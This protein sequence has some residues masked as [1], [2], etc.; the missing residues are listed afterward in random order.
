MTPQERQMVKDLFDRLAQ[1]ENEPRDAEAEQ[2]I[3][4]GLAKAPHAVY[5]L[6]QSVLVQDEAL[7]QADAHIQ[8]LEAAFEQGGGGAPREQRGFLDN[9]R[10]AVFG[11]E[12]PRGSVPNVRPGE[13]PMGVPP[14]Y[15]SDPGGFGGGSPWGGGM[16]PGGMAP[17]GMAPGGM[18]PGGMQGG[19]MQGGPMPP[20][21]GRG[22]SFLGTAAATAVGM[23]GS[24]L[25]LDG[26]RGMLGG[27]H[28]RG[29]AAGAF[30]QI[31]AGGPRTSGGGG[32]GGELGRDAGIDDIGRGGGRH[33][34][35]G[36]GDDPDDQHAAGVMDSPEDDA[37]YD[38]ADLDDDFGDG[39]DDQ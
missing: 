19:G 20:E 27:G 24:G 32:S 7:K 38:D 18:A 15:R 6:V 26:I 10:D 25:L 31:A 35:F 23:I 13:Q 9:M 17:G 11:R 3:R 37:E 28:H 33:G 1:L 22:G 21:P 14:Q 34:L 4:D 29:P 30:D 36:G 12:G 8:E 16:A 2:L 5:A 39:D